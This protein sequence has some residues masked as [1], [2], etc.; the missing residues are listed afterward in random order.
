MNDSISLLAKKIITKFSAKHI[1]LAGAESCTGGAIASAIVSISGASSIFKG[2]AVCYCDT[3]KVDILGVKKATLEKHFAESNQCAIEMAIGAL[4]IYNADIAF[5]STGFLDS[6][7][8]TLKE[9]LANTAF[10]A[11]ATKEGTSISKKI[12]FKQQSTR[13]Q[14]RMECVF[15]VLENILS[16]TDNNV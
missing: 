6:N 8:T 4:R 7:T 1:S 5:A 14:N 3:A 10:I 15:H 11:I 9:S 16:I 2:S 13:N 12:T